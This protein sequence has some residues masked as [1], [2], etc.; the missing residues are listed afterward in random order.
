MTKKNILLLL[1]LNKKNKIG[2]NG[3]DPI[4]EILN[5]NIEEVYI[6]D[7]KTDNWNNIKP[8]KLRNNIAVK[9]KIYELYKVNNTQKKLI[10]TNNNVLSSYK[11]KNEIKN[12][13]LNL[14]N[15]NWV[16]KLGPKMFERLDK[17]SNTLQ[18]LINNSFRY[19][20]GDK[21]Y[22]CFGKPLDFYKSD[23]IN[24]E[25]LP[26]DFLIYIHRYIFD[27]NHNKIKQ[28]HKVQLSETLNLKNTKYT[29]MAIQL[30]DDIHYWTYA[31]RLNE[32]NKSSWYNLN[33]QNFNP[34]EL[35]DNISKN[36]EKNSQL[37]LYTKEEPNLG[38]LEPVGIE[39]LATEENIYIC[40][41]SALTQLLATTYPY[42]KKR[43]N[44]LNKLLNDMGMRNKNIE[45][46]TR[47]VLLTN[48]FKRKKEPLPDNDPLKAG[49]CGTFQ[50]SREVL[51]KIFKKELDE[52]EENF[53]F[54]LIS[55]IKT[56]YVTCDSEKIEKYKIYNVSL[57]ENQTGG[58]KI[59]YFRKHKGIN[60]NTGKLNKGY[61]YSGKRL[62]SGMLEIKK[63][64]NII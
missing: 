28:D 59:K 63:S 8:E 7:K 25:N 55:N 53:E 52:I 24:G 33:D 60:Q 26:N 35:S 22:K 29:L 15:K 56:N 64:R 40:Y 32:D 36:I 44:N 58:K 57:P 27:E 5:M 61:K 11:N 51:D 13:L 19:Q 39:N 3:N 9:N 48:F 18:N 46:K 38:L 54:G 41:L 42:R 37:F 31:R 20:L 62:K 50:D 10:L 1:K 12:W 21:G 2:G 23:E 43:N 47:G 14:K 17:K 16:D 45:H 4:G 6:I 30:Y 34:I 49:D